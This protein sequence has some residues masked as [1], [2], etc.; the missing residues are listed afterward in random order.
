MSSTAHQGAVDEEGEEGGGDAEGVEA[1][2]EEVA[3]TGTKG[4]VEPGG[5]W[6]QALLAEEGWRGGVVRFLFFEEDSATM[7][8][9]CVRGLD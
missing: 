9:G 3:E 7:R 5:S 1:V 2:V 8:V 4:D 6:G